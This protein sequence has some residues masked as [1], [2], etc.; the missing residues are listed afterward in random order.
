MKKITV[1]L[2]D[3]HVAVRE[4]LRTLL[5]KEDDIKIIGE[6][7]N[8]WQAVVFAS[9]LCPDVVVMDIAIPLLNGLEATNQIRRHIPS[10]KVLV[11]AAQVEAERIEQARALGAS[12]LL[13]KQEAAAVLPRAIREIYNGTSFFVPLKQKPSNSNEP[14]HRPAC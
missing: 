14:D 6:A 5:K 7:V 10:T 9:K 8:G 11:L 3:D 1:L 12:A 13:A 4:D 2:A